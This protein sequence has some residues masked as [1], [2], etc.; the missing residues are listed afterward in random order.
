[1]KM[2][3]SSRVAAA[4]FTS[5][6]WY[7]NWHPLKI[8]LRKIWEG[9]ARYFPKSHAGLRDSLC[10]KNTY[11]PR[12]NFGTLCLLVGSDIDQKWTV[13]KIREIIQGGLEFTQSNCF[14]ISSW[15]FL[16]FS[17]SCICTLTI[18]IEFFNFSIRTFFHHVACL[19]KKEISQSI[20]KVC[21]IWSLF[22]GIL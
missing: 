5:A 4:S 3:S 19:Y 22:W 9:H 15:C 1:M 13:Q 20:A 6:G 10:S 17:S 16:Q 8:R 18:G 14:T 11:H 2:K 21:N 12:D 7:Q